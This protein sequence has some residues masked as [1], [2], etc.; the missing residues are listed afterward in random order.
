MPCSTSAPCRITATRSAISATTPKSWVMNMMA[1]PCLRLQLL[2]QLEDLRLGGDVERGGRL[3]G[4]DQRGL[5]RQRHGDHHALALAAGQLVRVA[6]QDA[7]GL[8]QA[9]VART[10]RRRACGARPA[11]SLVCTSMI[12]SV[13]RPTVISGLSATIGSWK[14]MA[15]RPPRTARMSS[16]GKRQQVLALEHARGRR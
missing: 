9:H 11:R 10:P 4:D 6:G 7:L 13:W 14:I 16:G 2:E 5:Q 1:V 3:V 8:G 12:S 15:M